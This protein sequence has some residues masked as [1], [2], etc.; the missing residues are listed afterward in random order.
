M[1]TNFYTYKQLQK[2]LHNHPSRGEGA[3]S[4]NT[5]GA[6]NKSSSFSSTDCKVSLQPALKI[7]RV[8]TTWSYSPFT[9]SHIEAR[10]SSI[11]TPYFS[12]LS[13]HTLSQQLENL[14]IKLKHLNLASHNSFLLGLRN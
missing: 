9:S 7:L 1:T 8:T 12:M 6:S 11:Q 14:Q 3:Y 10:E 5:L 13:A 2:L 4:I